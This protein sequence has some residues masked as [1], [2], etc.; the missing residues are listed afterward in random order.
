TLAGQSS[1]STPAITGT[2]QEGQTLTASASA[3]NPNDTVTYQ[4]LEN[5]GAGGAFQN[6]AGATGSTYLV[7]AADEGF[8]IEAA[9][10]ATNGHGA[11]TCPTRRATDPT[12]AGPSSVS[13]PAI[14]G[15]PQEGQTLTASASAGQGDNTVTYQWM[16]NSGSGGTFQNIAGA[17]G[18]TYLVT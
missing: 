12:L 11:T 18:S 10:T 17:T 9:A 7:K 14:T 1:V 16:E 2:P 15:T 6:I 4:W 5:N 13:T 8:T 3:G